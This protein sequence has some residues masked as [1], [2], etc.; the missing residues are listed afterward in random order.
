[1]LIG[2]HVFVDEEHGYGQSHHD[3]YD[4][5]CQTELES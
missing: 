4:T 2:I 1:M 3:E 5:D